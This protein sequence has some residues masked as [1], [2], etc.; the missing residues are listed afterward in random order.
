MLVTL[1]TVQETK[2]QTGY[3]D[4]IR[5]HTTKDQSYHAELT[6]CMLPLPG[7]HPGLLADKK[8]KDKIVAIATTQAMRYHAYI[9]ETLGGI[10]P[11]DHFDVKDTL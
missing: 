10:P 4:Y 5:H 2:Q 6:Y 9:M 1:V 3:Y 7:V 11:S 8:K